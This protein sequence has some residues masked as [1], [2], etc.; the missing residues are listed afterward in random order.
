MDF[1]TKIRINKATVV[2]DVE[3]GI[4]EETTPV[5]RAAFIRLI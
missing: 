3:F 1:K 5:M 2:S 4:E